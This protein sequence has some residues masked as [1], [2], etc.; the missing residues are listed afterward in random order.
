MR[1]QDAEFVYDGFTFNLD[2]YIMM[3]DPDLVTR[4]FAE[5]RTRAYLVRRRDAA[6]VARAAQEAY[7]AGKEAA[8]AAG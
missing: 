6:I 8:R 2:G 3:P 4:Q 1:N 7:R 5:K